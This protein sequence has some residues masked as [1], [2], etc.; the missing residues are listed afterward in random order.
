MNAENFNPKIRNDAKD[1]KFC[2]FKTILVAMIYLQIFKI[3]TPVSDYLQTKGLINYAKV[4]HHI[5]CATKS[6]NEKRSTFPNIMK[7]TENFANF[8]NNKIENYT[9]IQICK[10]SLFRLSFP[11]FG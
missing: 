7:A 9:L 1:L 6:L 10:I 11:K 2:T 5:S 4:W 3:I 8:V